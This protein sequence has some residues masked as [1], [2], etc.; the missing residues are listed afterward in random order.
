MEP[1]PAHI[2]K[3]AQAISIEMKLNGHKDW[4]LMEIAD[5]ALVGK[6]REQ[7]AARVCISLRDEFAKAALQGWAAGR[8]QNME[9]TDPASVAHSCYGYADA[10]LAERMRR[11]RNETPHP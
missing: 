2:M 7:L 8:N 5:R 1:I 11:T 6:L 9:H 3:A 4:E 10:M